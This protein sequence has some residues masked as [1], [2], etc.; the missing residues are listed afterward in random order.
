MFLILQFFVLFCKDHHSLSY[1]GL[2]ITA[3][4]ETLFLQELDICI[5]SQCKIFLRLD[6]YTLVCHAV[7][8][9]KVKWI[10]LTNTASSWFF[11][12]L[13]WQQISYD[14]IQIF[15]IVSNLI[16]KATGVQKY[17]K[18]KEEKALFAIREKISL[19]KG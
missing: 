11:L 4:W 2:C 5:H 8:W 12:K 3:R 6:L 16:T 15:F 9:N 1:F 10:L 19:T 18:E 14:I 13:R 7:F 17:R